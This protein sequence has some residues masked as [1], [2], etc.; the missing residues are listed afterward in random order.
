MR[1]LNLEIKSKDKDPVV[2]QYEE[3]E[4]LK[5]AIEVDGEQKVF[6]L[7]I[8]KRKTNW[9]DAERRI[10]FGGGIPAEIRDGLKN[11]S[12]EMMAEIAALLAK[13][14]EEA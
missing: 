2:R 13:A 8:Q 1:T 5:E 10:V 7:F 11:A 6:S 14:A 4:S 12:P 3:P 9:M